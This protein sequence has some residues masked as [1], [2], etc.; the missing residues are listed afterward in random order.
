VPVAALTAWQGIFDHGELA[1]GQRIL[2]TGASGAVGSM[3]VQLAKNK[4]AYVI[5]IGSGR[6]EEFVRKLGADKFIDYKKAKFEEKVSAVDVVFDTVGGD[7]QQPAVRGKGERVWRDGRDGLHDAKARST[8]GDKSPSRERE[9]KS[10]RS[11][12]VA[13]GRRDEGASTLVL[14]TR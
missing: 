5:G 4:G 2:I 6:N 10:A 9:I 8:R 7:T 14:R 1:S 12:G 11:N 3:T 13:A